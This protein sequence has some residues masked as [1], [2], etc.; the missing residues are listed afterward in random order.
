MII[1]GHRSDPTEP[2]S[3]QQGRLV[4]LRARVNDIDAGRGVK[5]GW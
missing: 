3:E 4:R 2:W 5:S 1:F